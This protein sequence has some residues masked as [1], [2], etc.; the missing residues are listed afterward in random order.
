MI[1]ERNPFYWKIDPEGNQ[2]PY[3]DRVAFDLVEDIEVVNMKAIAGEIDMQLRHMVIKNYP[4]FVQEG[5]KADYR[6]LR[7]KTGSTLGFSV[8]FNNKDPILRN[9]VQDVQFQAGY[10]SG[11]K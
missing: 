5:K 11:N 1:V 4:L 3:I 10:I 6:V 8:N 9:I 7:W 2:L